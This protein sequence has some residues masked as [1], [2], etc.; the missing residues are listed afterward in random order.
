MVDSVDSNTLFAVFPDPPER[1]PQFGNPNKSEQHNMNRVIRILHLEDSKF[2]AEI[3][4]RELKISK[5]SYERTWVTNKEEFER[6]LNRQVPDII[7]SDHSLPS[8]SS[9]QAFK[10]VRDM[11]IKV[12]F[13]L[14]TGTISE[15][16]A[17]S[18]MLEG[19][20]DYLLKDRM[21]RLPAAIMN[22]LNKFEAETEKQAYHEEVVRNEH[23]FRALIENISDA[24]I[25]VDH[26]AKFIYQSP[27]VSRITGYAQQ[28][29][30]GKTLFDLMHP[31]DV[32]EAVT[33]FREIY[34]Q[35]GVTRQ[36][37]YRVVNK[38]GHVIWLEGTITNLLLDENVQGFIV[39]YRDITQ[40]KLSEQATLEVM[41]RL[42]Q[43]NNDLRQ[44]AYIVSHDLRAPI[45][46]IQ[47]LVSLMESESDESDKA[48]LQKYITDEANHLDQVVMDMNDIVTASDSSQLRREEVDFID[49]LKSAEKVLQ[50]EIRESGAQ[51]FAD[52]HL[53]P[54]VHLVKSYM[55]SVMFNLLSNAIKY[56]SPQRRPEIYLSTS[57]SDGFAC[58]EVRDNGI[59]MDMAKNGEKIFDL[60]RRIDSK[61]NNGRGIGL[62]LVKLQVESMGGRIEVESALGEGSTFRIYLPVI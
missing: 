20:A 50:K 51:I 22:A 62:Y 1:L 2:D 34:Q 7:L 54:T 47:G 10:M 42:R 48:T 41:E 52:F 56:R 8:F 11:G 9:V 60:Y 19:A 58:L 31:D 49:K 39:N 40:R 23:K 33:F 16:F 43:R 45:A 38:D 36:N 4:E 44:F 6:E 35:P 17:V 28:E 27:S 21:Q 15:E 59:G 61:R 3:A 30:E 32:E 18:M 37:Q 12:P 57:L 24:I 25:L 55:Y 26:D 13:I 46:K 5:L 29:L 53:A 14:I